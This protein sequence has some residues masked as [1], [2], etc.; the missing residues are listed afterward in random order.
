MAS[1][2]QT[3]RDGRAVLGN[4]PLFMGTGEKTMR[5]A[6]DKKKF[7]LEAFDTLFNKRDYERAEEF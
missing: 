1:I 2:L 7:A 4:R 3:E 6:S 5:D